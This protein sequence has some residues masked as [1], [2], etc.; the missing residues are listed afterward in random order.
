MLAQRERMMQQFFMHP[1]GKGMSDID[2]VR[3]L[4]LGAIAAADERAAAYT[5]LWLPMERAQGDGDAAALERFMITFVSSQRHHRAANGHSQPMPQH[6]AA[7]A[8]EHSGQAAATEACAGGAA[9]GGSGGSGAEQAG[10]AEAEHAAPSE[11]QQAMGPPPPR[12]V[13]RATARPAA[14]PDAKPSPIAQYF[15]LLDGV[16]TLLRERGGSAGSA[17]LYDHGTA[18]AE[19]SATVESGAASRGALELRREMSAAA[20]GAAAETPAPPSVPV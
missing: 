14:R 19:S 11:G 4:L 5:E 12:P 2:L 17:L 20:V 15:S 8:H 7:A 10:Q 1:L 13:A 3:N 18:H 16:Q 9:S 6:G